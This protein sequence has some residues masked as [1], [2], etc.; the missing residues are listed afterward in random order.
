MHRVIDLASHRTSR[1]VRVGRRRRRRRGRDHVRRTD[2]R[3]V[4]SR[5]QRRPD[6]ERCRRHA[7]SLADDQKY[8]I[9]TIGSLGLTDASQI[10]VLFNATEPGGDGVNV[11]DVTLK[12]YSSTGTLL[13][14]STV[15]RTS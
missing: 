7:E 2:R 11:T 9:P 5:C 14:R 1:H 10:G 3:R 13:G 12:F 6:A 8:G 4:G 15:P